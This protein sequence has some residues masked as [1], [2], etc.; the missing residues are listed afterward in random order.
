MSGV[1]VKESEV[2]E[3]SKYTSVLRS[4]CRIHD[5]GSGASEMVELYY[6]NQFRTTQDR[7]H[8]ASGYSF[9]VL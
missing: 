3:Q 1:G 5:I 6:I 4:N 9:R 2:T 7:Y 8:P